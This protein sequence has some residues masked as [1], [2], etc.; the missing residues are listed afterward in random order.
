MN[1]MTNQKRRRR[2][3]LRKTLCG[4][5][6]LSLL[7]LSTPGGIFSLA[8]PAAQAATFGEIVTMTWNVHGGN[9]PGTP[10]NQNCDYY[11]LK[12]S[13]LAKVRYVL[14]GYRVDVAALQEIHRFQAEEM[15]KTMRQSDSRFRAYFF[16]NKICKPNIPSLDYGSV[17]ISRLPL[18]EG[19]YIHH[20]FKDQAPQN[21]Q[22]PESASLDGYVFKVWDQQ[23]RIYNSH[24]SEA[25]PYRQKQLAELRSLIYPSSV[26]PN[27]QRTRTILM[28][29]FNMPYDTRPASAYMSMR[30]LFLD[31]WL[32][33]H[34]AQPELGATVP[35]RKVRL[36]Y[37]FLGDRRLDQPGYQTG[38]GIDFS[39]ILDTNNISDHYPVVAHL[40]LN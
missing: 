27:V 24:P 25:E 13:D 18:V 23:I 14:A 9:P 21:T 38:F 15:A 7:L 8:V 31:S 26:Q 1:R 32:S 12:D 22:R 6:I 37:I 2:I 4:V 10:N 39:R 16:A 29:D 19:T 35:G 33:M 34:P 20:I 3:M 30:G 40:I 17:I 36:D 11:N 5:A 28:G